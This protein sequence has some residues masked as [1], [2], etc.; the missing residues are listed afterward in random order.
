M[1]GLVNMRK[2]R[3]FSRILSVALAFAVAVSMLIL[4]SCTASKH[5]VSLTIE[6]ASGKGTLVS[7]V[8]LPTDATDN[9]NTYVKNVQKIA[10]HLQ[11]KVDRL[12]STEGIY[13]IA[14]AGKVSGG[15]AI[16]M[17]YSFSDINDYNRKTMR[18]FYCIPRSVRNGLS[19]LGDEYK[20][21][22]FTQSGSDVTFSQSGDIFTAI[23]LWAY[24]YMLHNDIEDAWDYTGDQQAAQLSLFGAETNATIA[25]VCRTVEI[26]VGST[27]TT[28]TAYSGESVQT[29]SAT[30]SV[31][32]TFVAV[33]TSVTDESIIVEHP[34]EIVSSEP[35]TN[36]EG[37]KASLPLIYPIST[38]AI[39]LF[40]AIAVVI[41]LL[42][43]K[44][45]EDENNA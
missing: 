25:T 34:E 35:E 17:T 18:L 38:V 4:T 32:G 11:G 23:N 9:T 28:A 39:A 5:T 27:K 2:H 33:D 1:K 44:A 22:T 42:P 19:S 43:K 10:E 8:M 6:D 40:M 37:E 13:T 30:G 7:T 14:Y 36:N 20:F 12:T 3:I 21:A 31:S 16:T 29:V 15:E 45:K 26:T 41:T 24:D